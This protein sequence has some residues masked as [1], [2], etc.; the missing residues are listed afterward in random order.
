MIKNIISS[1]ALYVVCLAFICI[2]SGVV[3]FA[4]HTFWQDNAKG[5]LIVDE[6]ENVRGSILLAQQLR[7]EE[8]FSP[9]TKEKFGSS[10]DVAL[11]NDRL[12]TSLLER[13]KE[14]DNPYDI[15]VLTPS[16]SLLDPYI[17]KRDAIKQ[18]IQ[19]AEKRGLDSDT[20]LRLVEDHSLNNSE[21]FFE[22]EIVN[23]TILNAI[24]AGYYK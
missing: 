16:S 12:R 20:L 6:N 2:Y 11:Y 5:S 9:R 23:T 15:A 19:I 24:L 13:Y 10:C 4:G 3:Y 21:P 22:L 18:A 7:K 8:Y 17:M 1:L 14:A